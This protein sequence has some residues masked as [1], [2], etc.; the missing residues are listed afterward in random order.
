MNLQSYYL[1]FCVHW[2]FLLVSSVYVHI[3][4]TPSSAFL[5]LLQLKLHVFQ[6]VYEVVDAV[7]T[8]IAQWSLTLQTGISWFSL[9]PWG[10]CQ[11]STLIRPQPLPLLLEWLAVEPTEPCS[12]CWGGTFSLSYPM[13]LDGA[14]LCPLYSPHPQGEKSLVLIRYEAGWTP[15][16]VWTK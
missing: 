13:A 14:D 10:R 9:N 12:S 5:Q 3:D 8:L 2:P 7:V 6:S 16:L 15:E 4:H 1:T 11:E